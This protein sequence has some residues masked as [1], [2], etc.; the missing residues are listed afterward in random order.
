[1]PAT[2]A[3]PLPGTKPMSRPAT[4]AAAVCST[5]KPFQPGTVSPSSSWVA[6]WIMPQF[7][8]IARA[9][10]NTAAPSLRVS[11]PMPTTIIGFLA[12]FSTS[13]NLLEP[14][15]TSARVWVPAPRCS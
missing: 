7:S 2:S 12:A 13:A 5:L 1:M 6:G 4:R 11:A 15:A 8:A 10:A 9:A 14:S 3:P